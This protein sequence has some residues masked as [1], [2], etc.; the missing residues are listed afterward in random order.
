MLDWLREELVEARFM[1]SVYSVNG[2]S[3]RDLSRMMYVCLLALEILRFEEPSDAARY[4]QQTMWN[5]EYDKLRPSGTDLYNIMSILSNQDKYEDLIKTDYDISPGLL[6]VNSYLRRVYNGA[7]STPQDRFVLLN[8]A[9]LLGIDTVDLVYARRIASQWEYAS[10]NE[11]K[12]A[13]QVLLN[14]I[15]RLAPTLDIFG[16]LRNIA[17]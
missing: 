2:K 15:R 5:G 11:Q 8:V 9:N 13:A 4:A 6:E 17:I 16:H 12:Q 14:N 7:N 10:R 3:A 1:R